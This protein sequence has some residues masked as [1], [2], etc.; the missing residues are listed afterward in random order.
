MLT[1]INSVL[2]TMLRHAENTDTRQDIQREDPVF[3]QRKKKSG[4]AATDID[5]ITDIAE[6]SIGALI[7]FLEAEMAGYHGDQVEVAIPPETSMEPA[8]PVAPINPVITQAA[9]AYGGGMPAQPALP[10]VGASSVVVSSGAPR[11]GLDED[12][13]RVLRQYLQD[14]KILRDNMVEVLV[15]RRS[16]TFLDSLADAIHEHMVALGRA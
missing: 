9:K 6:V 1:R 3:D 10:P 13:Q 15:M 8:P 4:T 5:A 2:G 16:G 12:G 14:L 11:E 7:A